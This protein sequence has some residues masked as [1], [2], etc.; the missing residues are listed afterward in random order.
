MW[1]YICMSP[2]VYMPPVHLYAPIC[3]YSP[4]TSVHPLYIYM[5][6]VHLYTPLCLYIPIPV[7][8]P[9][10]PPYVCMPPYIYTSPMHRFSANFHHVLPII[11]HSVIDTLNLTSQVG[12][13]QKISRLKNQVSSLFLRISK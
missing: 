3:L 1:P 5:P 7:H 4:H 8:V 12:S 2:Y 10:H 9:V 11:E 13:R 6:P